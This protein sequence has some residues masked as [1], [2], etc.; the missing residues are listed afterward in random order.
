MLMSKKDSILLLLTANAVA[1]TQDST[2]QLTTDLT[3]GSAKHEDEPLPM[4]VAP[5]PI[6]VAND[7]IS[8]LATKPATTKPTAAK[9]TTAATHKARAALSSSQVTAASPPDVPGRV[10]VAADGASSATVPAAS[11]VG[12]EPSS[13][14]SS[15]SSFLPSLFGM[16]P[17]SPTSSPARR[18]RSVS[19]RSADMISQRQS[20]HSLSHSR[21]LGKVMRAAFGFSTSSSPAHSRTPSQAE[22]RS[23]WAE[24]RTS[25]AELRTSH[26]GSSPHVVP[27]R[28]IATDNLQGSRTMH[29]LRQLLSSPADKPSMRASS[30]SAGLRESNGSRESSSSHKHAVRLST[31]KSDSLPSHPTASERSQRAFTPHHSARA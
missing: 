23:S 22:L 25:Q 18:T 3:Q 19:S 26:E 31:I 12:W 14:P 11:W 1:I 17:V 30:S 16:E 29:R 8:F 5:P 27:L 7:T 9:P 21:G 28:Q 20:R 10:P 24:L 15:S 13:L 6:W 4:D 2:G